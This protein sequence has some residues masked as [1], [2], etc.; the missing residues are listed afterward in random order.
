ME[1]TGFE[2]ENKGGRKPPNTDTPCK[3]Y[4]LEFVYI[5]YVAL[6]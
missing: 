4:I 6:L 2:P 5:Y 1:M 3:C